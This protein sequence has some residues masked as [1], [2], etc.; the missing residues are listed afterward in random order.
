MRVAEFRRTRVRNFAGHRSPDSSLIPEPM[1]R[2]LA[3]AL[4]VALCAAAPLEA[5]TARPRTPDAPPAAGEAERELV[6][7]SRAAIIAA[8][9]SAPF[10]DKHFSV[11]K[12]VNTP[13]DRRVMWRFRAHGHETYVNDSVG[14][15][16]D[17]RGRRI[18]THSAAVTLAGARDLRRAITRRRAE[19]I[20]RSCIGPFEGGAVVFQQFGPQPRAALVFTASTPPPPEA[21]DLP[22]ST[23]P[24]EP[25]G[26]ADLQRGGKKG[27]FMSLGAVDLETGRCVKGVAQVG[28]PKPDAPRRR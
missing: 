5:Q 15:S 24:S 11:Y 17:A 14:S 25:S 16:A 7:S 19:R 8:G 18:N 6:R 28:A 21:S 20:M 23:F 22:A 27:P 1:K 10:F 4:A 13:G 2:R 3:F 26:N 12:V 9:F